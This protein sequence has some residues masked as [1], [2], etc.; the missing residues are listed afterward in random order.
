M[1]EK[2]GGGMKTQRILTLLR[3]SAVK[4]K[5]GKIK[6]NFPTIIW[7]EQST[8]K[9]KTKKFIDSQIVPEDLGVS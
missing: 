3:G 7:T 9:K 4:E 6:F 2:K 8:K 5:T 1:G